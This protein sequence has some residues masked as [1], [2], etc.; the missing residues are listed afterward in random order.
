M[1][2]PTRHSLACQGNGK[3]IKTFLTP[4]AGGHMIRINGWPLYRLAYTLSKLADIMLQSDAPNDK[5]IQAMVDAKPDL[6]FSV[7][8][9]SFLPNQSKIHAMAIAQKIAPLLEPSDF[10]LTTVQKSEVAVAITHFNVI[11]AADLGAFDLYLITPK[12]AYNTLTLLT[13]ARSIFPVAVRAALSE[14]ITYEVQQ[15]ANCLEYEAFSAVGFHVLRA[16]ELVIL[17]YFTISGW[18][19]G[20][21][22]SWVGYCKVLR[23]H[24]VHR[25]IVAMV[26]RLATLHRNELMHA[27]AVLLPAESVILF[28]L[29]Q[30]ILPVM[31]A[32]VANRKGTPI[33]DFPILDDPRWQS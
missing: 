32:D 10:P 11:L 19:R 25:K 7:S 3:A 14:R 18:S 16:V 21:A 9:A 20:D 2:T 13:D 23:N 31:V 29:M 6:E 17:D 8:D 26:E 28:S 5:L 22:N 33:A 4:V 27:E 1:L 15:A 30:E 24:G 12:L